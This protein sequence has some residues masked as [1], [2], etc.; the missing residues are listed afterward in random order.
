MHPIGMEREVALLKLRDC[1]AKGMYDD[2]IQEEICYAPDVI[3]ELREELSARESS[4]IRQRPTEEIYA[5]YIYEQRRCIADLNEVVDDFK[6]YFGEK[7]D[8]KGDR[9]KN[10]NI[11]GYVGAV[12]TRSEILDKIL[13]TGQDLGIIER[14]SAS[15]GLFA[16]QAII[17]MTNIELKQYVIGEMQA[18]HRM[19]ADFGDQD[20]TAIEVGPIHKQIGPPKDPVKA[21]ARTAV[22]GGRRVVKEV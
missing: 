3:K 10:R 18:L 16:G 22:H 9:Q 4:A 11:N 14:D 21:H 6:T 5:L 8:E 20:I 13:K 15:K 1:L 12:K 19:M 2:E 7:L 17:N